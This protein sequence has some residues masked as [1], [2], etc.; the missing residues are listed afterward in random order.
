MIR[1]AYD[2]NNLHREKKK[3]GIGMGGGTEKHFLSNTTTRVIFPSQ[4]LFPVYTLEQVFILYVL[5]YMSYVQPYCLSVYEYTGL[6][7]NVIYVL[8]PN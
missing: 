2:L 8:M 6:V 7:M 4:R 1:V 3:R 5:L